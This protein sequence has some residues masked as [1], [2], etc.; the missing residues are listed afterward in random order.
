MLCYIRQAGSTGVICDE[1][2][3]NN[4]YGEDHCNQWFQLVVFGGA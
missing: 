2:H 1:C 4:N 3:P